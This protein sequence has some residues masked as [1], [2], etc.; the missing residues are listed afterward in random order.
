M[1]NGVPKKGTAVKKVLSP[2]QKLL[3]MLVVTSM[4]GMAGTIIYLLTND[5]NPEDFMFENNAI[6]GLMPGVDRD[7]LLAEMQ[8]NVD[9]SAIAFSINSGPILE[10]SQINIMFENPEGNNKNLVIEIL[11]NETGHSLY[12]SRAIREGSYMEH[13]RLDGNLLSGQHP[14]TVYITAYAIDTN[15]LIGQA[16]VEIVIHS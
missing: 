5:T 2:K 1:S 9:E 14:A 7:A 11:H 3:R 6:I 13:V 16:A 10:N 15:E 8:S 12:T 4:V